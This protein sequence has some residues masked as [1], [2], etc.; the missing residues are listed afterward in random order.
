M[1]RV[2]KRC[3]SARLHVPCA[4]RECGGAWAEADTI[5]DVWLAALVI[6]RRYPLATL[7]PAAVLGAIGEVPVYLID[8]RP[9]AGPG[10]HP[11]ERLRRLLPVPGI[12]RGD[13]QKGPTGNP[14][15][16]LRSMLDDLMESA[17]FV[18]RVLGAA[19]ISLFVTTAAI[20]L[21]VI[22]GMWLYTRWSLATPVI[23]DESVGP[24]PRCDA[25]TNSCAVTSGSCS[26]RRPW[27]IT[28]KG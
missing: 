23:R 25:A 22:P 28:S 13:R 8:G 19:L 14:R 9:R 7:V 11:G 12:R 2:A 17:P 24:S 15:P 16:R 3:E 20:G 5:R 6:F 27:P 4:G 10:R 21:L 1:P 18:P 26:Q